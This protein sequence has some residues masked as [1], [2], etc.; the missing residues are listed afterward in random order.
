[1]ASSQHLCQGFGRLTTR[2]SQNEYIEFLRGDKPKDTND[3]FAGI[4]TTWNRVKNG[5]DI[6]LILY[7]IEKNFDFGE[8]C[9]TS[10]RPNTCLQKNSIFGG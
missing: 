8:S 4:N 10:K 1:M 6:G 2:G 7:D 9:K 5:G 3:I